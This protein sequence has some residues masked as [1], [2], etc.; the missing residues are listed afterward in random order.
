MTVKTSTSPNLVPFA[1]CAAGTCLL[2]VAGCGKSEK[3][4]AADPTAPESY[5]NDPAFRQKLSADRK[6]RQGLLRAR[7][8]IVSQMKAMIDAKKRE[9]GTDDLP[10][11]KAELEK[12]P[13][14]QD[15]CKQCEE[16]TAKVEASRKA[17]LN[18]VRA[19]ITPKEP[20]SK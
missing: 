16:A 17:T 6:A 18:T 1:F 19:R 9:L 3:A 15:L 12:D 11:V 2:L 14:W 20:I 7:S 8:E 5:M 4:A 13:A 10:K